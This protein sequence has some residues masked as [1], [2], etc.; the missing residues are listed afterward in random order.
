MRLSF[1]QKGLYEIEWI[2]GLQ[3][4][5]NLTSI[6]ELFKDTMAFFQKKRQIRDR[7]SNTPPSTIR[8]GE[9]IAGEG[10]CW[11]DVNPKVRR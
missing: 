1:L 7:P 4:N 8:C 9:R 2:E 11:V 3:L 10:V 6:C 5:H